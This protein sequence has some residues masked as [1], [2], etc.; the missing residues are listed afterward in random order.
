[1]C[2]KNGTT[3][4]RILL[5]ISCLGSLLLS[6]KPDFPSAE[7]GKDP[8]EQRKEELE[9]FRE[10]KD[11]SFKEDPQSP[12]K[13]MDR[14]KFNGLSYYPIDLKYAMIGSIDRYPIEPKPLY[15]NLPTSKGTEKNM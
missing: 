10:K 9:T 14:K 7:V 11:R 15:A 12:L 1:M 2:K 6:G 5:L 8:A 3:P 13:E 4:T